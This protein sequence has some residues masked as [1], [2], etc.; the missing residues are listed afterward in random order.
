ME[1]HYLMST[2]MLAIFWSGLVLLALLV[3]GL[4]L[5]LGIYWGKSEAERAMAAPASKQPAPAAK[6]GP[7]NVTSGAVTGPQAPA[8]PQPAVPQPAAPSASP[9]R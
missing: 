3:F 4:G 1:H 8:G 9:T 6:A 7:S 2:R 5:T